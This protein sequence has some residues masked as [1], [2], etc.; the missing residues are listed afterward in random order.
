MSLLATSG[1]VLALEVKA[2]IGQVLEI[3]TLALWL[4]HV[5][6]AGLMR[7]LPKLKYTGLLTRSG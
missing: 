4:H 2:C 3:A 5:S 7:S 1:A 6:L